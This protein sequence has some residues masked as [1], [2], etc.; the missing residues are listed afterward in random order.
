[1]LR[2]H[3]EIVKKIVIGE[4]F[5]NT[6]FDNQTFNL[7]KSKEFIMKTEHAPPKETLTKRILNTLFGICAFAG[8]FVLAT[9]SISI[10]LKLAEFAWTLFMR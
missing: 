5:A 3:P 6:G 8:F 4:S 1:M 9:F 7:L 10:G 2:A